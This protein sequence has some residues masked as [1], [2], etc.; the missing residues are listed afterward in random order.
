MCGTL[1]TLNRIGR[2]ITD[3]DDAFG[4]AVRIQWQNEN[5]VEEAMRT[6]A[7]IM[8]RKGSTESARADDRSKFYEALD[9]IKQLKLDAEDCWLFGK[10]DAVIFLLEGV[11]SKNDGSD[12]S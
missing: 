5:C 6:V 7:L 3:D 10:L 9:D 2:R 12:S 8:A 11:I 1:R 4:D